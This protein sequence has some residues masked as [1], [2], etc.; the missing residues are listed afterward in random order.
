MEPQS[1]HLKVIDSKQNLKGCVHLFGV[2]PPVKQVS[3]S[4][5]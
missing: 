4:D 2:L 1:F 3:N 5:M